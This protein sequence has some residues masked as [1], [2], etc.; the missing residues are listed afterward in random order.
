MIISNPPS[1]WKRSRTNGLTYLTTYWFANYSS[2]VM[3]DVTIVISV[4]F[5]DDGDVR[6]YD[7]AMY[8][9]VYSVLI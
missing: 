4:M 6:L 3:W 1:V 5:V 9:H 8:V 2:R 7:K